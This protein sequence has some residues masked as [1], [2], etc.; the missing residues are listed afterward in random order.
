MVD[1]TFIKLVHTAWPVREREGVAEV[2]WERVRGGEGVLES[3]Q[4]T[5]AL[6]RRPCDERLAPS[7]VI[8]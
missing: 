6:H 5:A 7:T 2:G 8:P 1:V 4:T 3:D